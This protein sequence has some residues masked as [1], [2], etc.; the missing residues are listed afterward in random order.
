MGKHLLGVSAVL[1]F[2]ATAVACDGGTTADDTGTGGIPNAT[3]G[4]GTGGGTPGTGGGTPGTGGAATGGTS[5]GGPTPS[6]F[7]E[8]GYGTSDPWMGYLFTVVDEVGGTITPECDDAGTKPCFTESGANLCASGTLAA[9]Y[10]SFALIGWNINQPQ[11]TPPAT[12]APAPALWTTTGTGVKA[13]FT[14][15][16][17]PTAKFRV[18]LQGTDKTEQWC[19]EATSGTT[20]NWTD[21]KTNCWTGGTPQTPF[22]VGTGI[23]QIQVQQYSPSETATT[24]FDFCVNTI[25][26]VP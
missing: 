3:G 1:G 26:L 18:Q 13:T 23:A 21:F 17:G 12:E 11:P 22:T 8:N 24:P 14:N 20:I 7:A 15:N 25:E 5:G 16:G 4:A 2:L 9:S 19:A 6:T 10:E